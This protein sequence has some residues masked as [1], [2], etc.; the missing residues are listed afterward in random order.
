MDENRVKTVVC[1]CYVTFFLLL[2]LF[3]SPENITDHIKIKWFEM[4]KCVYGCTTLLHFTLY[5]NITYSYICIHHQPPAWGHS[6]MTHTYS[7]I[8][9]SNS[10]CTFFQTNFVGIAKVLST[11]PYNPLTNIVSNLTKCCHFESLSYE[12]WR[13]MY[14]MVLPFSFFLSFNKCV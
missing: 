12:T 1:S 3:S 10:S 7:I 14:Q 13:K 5:Y 6:T 11:S 8:G 2:F 4:F 9:L